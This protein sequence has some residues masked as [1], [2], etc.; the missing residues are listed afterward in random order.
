MV[1]LQL[2]A[3]LCFFALSAEAKAG[4]T[5]SG[6][7]GDATG[8]R[9]WWGGVLLG[10]W[11][12]GQGPDLLRGR[13]VLELG[14]GA[15]PLPGMAAA[16]RGASR[17]LAT[18]GCPAAVRAA[19]AVLARNAA[20]PSTCTVDRQAWEE[21]PKPGGERAWD[22][23]IFA[24]VIYSEEG[25]QLLA[26]AVDRHVAAGGWVLGAVGLLR[27]GSSDVFG[28]M[29]RLGFAAAE[30]PVSPE[31]LGRAASAA[32]SL[33]GANATDL[34]GAGSASEMEG[35]CKLVRWVRRSA[36]PPLWDGRDEAAALERHAVDFLHKRESAVTFAQGWEPCE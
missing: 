31:I 14:C 11:I 24:D 3:D 27:F 10:A 20:L 22:V 12:A 15:A 1:R 30:V 33:A 7:G 25:A 19:A 17:V 6:Y 21:P 4:T 32:A 5:A 23:V 2:S 8:A 26:A 34:G 9:P 35:R 28:R 36:G 13:S 29:S 18:D 16:L